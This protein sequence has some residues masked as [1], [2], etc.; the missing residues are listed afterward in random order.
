IEAA[1]K[2]KANP[3]TI[4]YPLPFN[5]ASFAMATP[6]ENMEYTCAQLG[7]PIETCEVPPSMA[8]LITQMEN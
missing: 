8:H 3:G 2:T 7:I 6:L 4:F 5:D 1:L